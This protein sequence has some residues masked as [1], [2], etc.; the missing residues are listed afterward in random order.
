MILSLRSFLQRNLNS[1]TRMSF[2]KIQNVLP[3]LISVVPYRP[4]P[5]F[6]MSLPNIDELSCS[7][8]AYMPYL[9]IEFGSKVSVSGLRLR[10]SVPAVDLNTNRHLSLILCVH[11][12]LKRNRSESTNESPTHCPDL[13]NTVVMSH[14]K[15]DDCDTFRWR[16]CRW[17]KTIE[18]NWCS[19]L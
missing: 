9:C 5:S 7:L 19:K 13:S 14:R 2:E 3:L 18:T 16:R 10:L 11:I 15:F 17:Q 6:K 8:T 1:K 4:A 12:L